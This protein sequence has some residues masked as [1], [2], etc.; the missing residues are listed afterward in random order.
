M[1]IRKDMKSSKSSRSRRLHKK[2]R[3][4]HNKVQKGGVASS[5]IITYNDNA[6]SLPSS[7][8]DMPLDFTKH[9]KNNVLVRKPQIK[10]VGLDVRKR[11]LMI[12]IDPNAIN[13][14]WTHWVVAIHFKS[15]NYNDMITKDIVEYTP[16]TP[17]KGSGIHKYKFELYQLANETD[18]RP[19]QNNE[20]GSYFSNVLQPFLKKNTIFLKASYKV[21]SQV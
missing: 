5:F 4:K 16:P 1:A 19:M 3:S 6:A 9:Y 12:M 10:L 7:Q 14:T 21:D 2:I 18:P 15:N 13:T 17:P 8:L 11:Y 20:R